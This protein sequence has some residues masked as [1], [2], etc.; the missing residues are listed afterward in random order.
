[1]LDR[2]KTAIFIWLRVPCT[3]VKDVCADANRRQGKGHV[4][5]NDQ[6]TIDDLAAYLNLPKETLYKYVRGGR[7]PAHKSGRRWV[8]DRSE[9][10]A[11]IADH[12]N[13]APEQTEVRVLLVDD[14]PG[15]RHVFRVWLEREGYVVSEAEDGVDALE[16]LDRAP[17]S[18]VFLD[19]QMPKMDGVQ[20]L[21]HIRGRSPSPDVVIVTAHYNGELMEEILRLGPVHVLK[22][23]VSRERFLDTARLYVSA[24]PE[25]HGAV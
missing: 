18:L 10:D 4:V 21:K 14:E 7:I 11:W 12:T 20:T 2:R 17:Y 3:T 8:F 22:K 15:V 13:D 1:M 6:M 25:T 9:I 16:E 23:P 24:A 19:L 5:N